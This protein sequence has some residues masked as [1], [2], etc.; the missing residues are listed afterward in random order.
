MQSFEF[1]GIFN[2]PLDKGVFPDQFKNAH[3]KPTYKKVKNYKDYRLVI[4]LPN[5]SW[6]CMMKY[7]IFVK[8]C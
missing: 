7:V 6:S 1:I 4:I 2:N 8:Y 3:A 5:L